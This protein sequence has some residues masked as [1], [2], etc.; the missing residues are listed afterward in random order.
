MKAEQVA[1]SYP[2]T[3]KVLQDISFSVQEGSFLAL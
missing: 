3:T 2:N 1:F